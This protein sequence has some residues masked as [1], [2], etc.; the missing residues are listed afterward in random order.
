VGQKAV[1]EYVYQTVLSV[2]TNPD[3]LHFIRQD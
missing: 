2:A 3:E 1:S